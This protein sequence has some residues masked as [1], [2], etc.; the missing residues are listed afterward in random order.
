[1]VKLSVPPLRQDKLLC[2]PAALSMV[3]KYFGVSFSSNKIADEIG[4]VKKYGVRT[5]KLAEFARKL[6]FTVYCYSFNEKMA[7][8]NAT[9]KKP[10]KS[11]ILK[12]L[13][14]GLPIILAVRSFILYGK[15]KSEMGHFIVVTGYEKGRF[16]YND[17]TDGKHHRMKEDDLL[18]AW[19][20]NALESSAYLLALKPQKP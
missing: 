8:G 5:I 9:D 18:F 13:K 2:G 1:M 20:N 11:D 17:P 14:M 12:F 16:Y 10:T 3:L 7:K 15:E 19:F 4:G 6:G